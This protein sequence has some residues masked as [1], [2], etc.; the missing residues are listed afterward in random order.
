[1]LPVT[2]LP[3]GQ[4]A[5]FMNPLWSLFVRLSDRRTLLALMVLIGIAG[6][7]AGVSTLANFTTLATSNDSVF[8]AGSIELGLKD[9]DETEFA[10][11]VSASIGAAADDWRP[12]EVRYAPLTVNNSGTLPLIYD[13][14]YTAADSGTTPDGPA[15]T[16]TEFLDLSIKSGG[17]AELCTAASWNDGTWSETVLD[18]QDLSTAGGSLANDRPLAANGDEEVL[19]LKVEFESAGSGAEN[20]A[21]GG[22]STL[23]FTFAGEQ[24]VATP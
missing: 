14:A 15:A 13:L 10:D 19:C 11:A 6:A 3:Y 22:T 7:T 18:S 5:D 8:T 23:D 20:S 9:A 1:L 17:T 24:L 12:G 2:A 16:L 4:E 21:Q